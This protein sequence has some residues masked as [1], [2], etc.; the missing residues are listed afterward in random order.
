MVL[1]LAIGDLHI[2][3]RSHALPNKFKKLLVPGK[4]QKIISTGN[5]VDKET[6]DYLKTIAGDIVAVKGDFDEAYS[7]SLPQAKVI[8]EGNL[9]IGI[10]HGHQ[11]IPWGDAEALDITARQMEV[12]VL[13]SGHTHKF[14]AYEY[15][16]RFFINPGSA[17]GAYSSIPDINE[18]IPSFVLMDI[19]G[20]AVVTYVY[21][22]IEDEVKVEKLEYKR[23]IETKML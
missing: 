21:K 4:I 22:L 6:F 2:P 23:T 18:P 9:R 5:M 15:N 10:V 13:V 19:Q 12:D 14:E 8:T 11:V 20:N 3:H 1:V 7:A 16:G 17:T